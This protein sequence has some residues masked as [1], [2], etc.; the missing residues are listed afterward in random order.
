[1]KTT[2]GK[3]AVTLTASDRRTEGAS[4]FLLFLKFDI[5]LGI[6]GTSSKSPE[7]AFFYYEKAR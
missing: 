3:G 4:F 1:M 7:V 6:R 2:L 5:G